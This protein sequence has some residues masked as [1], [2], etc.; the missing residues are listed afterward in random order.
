MLILLSPAKNLDFTP[1]DVVPTPYRMKDDA[2][3]LMQAV[4]KLTQA[5]IKSLMDL[6]DKLAALN[7]QRFQHLDPQ[8]TDVKSAI[9]AFNGDVYQGLAAKTLDAAGLARAQSMLRILSGLY[10][11]LRPLD[12]IQPYRL[13]MGRRLKTKRGATLYDFW[14]SR[15]AHQLAADV[16]GH[17]HP[18]IVNCASSEYFG[19]VDQKNLGVPVITCHFRQ[20]KDSVVK[21]IGL[22][23]KKARGQMARYAI[24]H[25][26][27]APEG[28]K[29]F[30]TDGY[31]FQP[32]LSSSTDWVFLRRL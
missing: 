21:T 31:G 6:S 1:T 5:K 22:Y 11:V 9:L 15:I 18:V 25:G 2:A 13:E 4:G 14:G 19:A 32:G 29:G 20:E 23:A 12:G 28:L 16:A 27:D 24:D 8:S 7:W 3:L 30:D 26:L 17:A 10:G